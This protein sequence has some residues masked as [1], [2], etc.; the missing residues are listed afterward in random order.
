MPLSDFKQHR[1]LSFGTQSGGTRSATEIQRILAKEGTC[2]THQ[3][4]TKTIARWQATGSVQDY[5]WSGR[6]QQ[7]PD[8][9]YHQ[10]DQTLTENDELTSSDLREG[11]AKEF[12]AENVQYSERTIARVQNELE[13]TFTTA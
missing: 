10:V 4:I 11:L 12:G 1:I 2:T 9:H 8:T 13:W 5:P 3:T 6:P 7:V